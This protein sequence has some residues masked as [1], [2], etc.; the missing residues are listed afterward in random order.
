MSWRLK[1][2]YIMQKKYA[3][4]CLR[5]PRKSAWCNIIY[6]GNCSTSTSKWLSKSHLKNS[7]MP[8]INPSTPRQYIL[9]KEPL[10][11]DQNWRNY[12]IAWFSCKFPYNFI[13]NYYINFD[14]PAQ[15]FL[16]IKW[17]QKSVRFFLI[18]ICNCPQV[19][20]AV[21]QFFQKC[22]PPSVQCAVIWL[23]NNM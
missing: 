10:K 22:A 13:H 19:P 16:V 23:R 3:K 8:G 17:G 14:L 15:L 1:S 9:A 7:I 20:N 6:R 21:P 11:S 4:E 5:T 18:Y 12:D 2:E